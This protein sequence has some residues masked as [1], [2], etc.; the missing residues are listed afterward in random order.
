MTRPDAPPASSVA[1]RNVRRNLTE[2]TDDKVRRVVA[3]VEQLTERGETDLLLQPLRPR[4]ARLRPARRLRFERLLFL[5]L[6]PVIV[7]PADWRPGRP[8]IPRTV[9]RSLGRIIRIALGRDAAAIDTL[10]AGRTSLDLDVIHQAGPVLWDDAGRILEMAPRPPQWHDDTGLNDAAYKPLA[11]AVGAVL[12]LHPQLDALVRDAENGLIA[13]PETEIALL[14]ARAADEPPE[15]QAIVNAILLARLPHAAPLLRALDTVPLDDAARAAMRRAS[16]QAVTAAL[17]RLDAAGGIEAAIAEAPLDG[18]GGEVR[19]L[20]GFLEGLEEQPNQAQ[21]RQRLRLLR[22]RLDRSCQTRF[23]AALQEDVI[24]PLRDLT[25]PVT[26]SAQSCLEASARSLRGLE[27]EARRI[28]G[29]DCYGRLLDEAAAALRD[30]ADAGYM[31]PGRSARLM[32]IVA[33]PEAAMAMLE[34]AA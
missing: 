29:A 8:S 31:P 34:A 23:A 24:T 32:E 7:P 28:G 2:T 17:D 21:R 12:R 10:I 9:I 22:Q 4:L 6:D 19:R 33:G 26:T 18:I 11:G 20:A 3:L 15:T 16:E 25:G 27:A 13:Q 14:L 5:P 1:L 30:A